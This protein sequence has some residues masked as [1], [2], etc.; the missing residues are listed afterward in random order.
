MFETRRPVPPGSAL[1]W[2]ALL[3][4]LFH[5]PLAIWLFAEPLRT[6]TAAL[7]AA[8]QRPMWPT[9]VVA[10]AV[11][12]LW[13]F[14]LALPFSLVPRAYRF[15]APL[16]TALGTVFLA[17]DA[18]VYGALGFHVNAFVL[19]VAMQPDALVQTGIPPREAAV[20]ALQALAFVAADV[21]VGAWFLRRFATARRT[22]RWALV[23]LLLGVTER[24]AVGA[25]T[26]YGGPGIF[27]AG[28]VL[29]QQVP[30][31]IGNLMRKVTGRE[32][33]VL[34]DPFSGETARLAAQLP[35]G[36][37]PADVK[38]TR[39]PDVLLVVTEST[40][41]TFLNPEVM[42]RMWKR[43]GAGAR[44]ER[45]YA[46]ANATSY[47]IFGLLFGMQAYRQEAVLGAGRRPLLF[48]ALRDH[49]YQLQFIAASSLDWMGLQDSVFADVKDALQ[50][51]L[52]GGGH[53]RDLE[54]LKR[55]RAYVEQADPSTPIFLFLFF[56]GTH[57]N[58]TYPERSAVFAPA[59]DGQGSV[60]VTAADHASV[61]NRARNAAHEVDWLTD[62]FLEW[63]QARRGGRQP[64]VVYT[65][66]HG[67]EF[68]EKGHMAH[69]NALTS[70]QIQVPMVILGEGVTP[71]VRREVTSH[72]DVVPTL[73]RLLGDGHDP[74][75][76]SDGFDMF[77]IPP[78]RFAMSTIGWEPEYAAVGEDLKVVFHALGVTVTDPEDR[79][80]PDGGARMA[81]ASGAIFRALGKD[82]GAASKAGAP[83]P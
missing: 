21:A 36:L 8:F 63:F 68:G 29:P 47:T 35:E 12:S 26:F 49:G 2:P 66:D 72:V 30:L 54:M 61:K 42:P 45:H 39:R 17:I 11:L 65:G 56:E 25:L 77:A 38:L 28:Q 79:P 9:Y 78:G 34:R 40:P 59:W 80:L 23:L 32:S 55:A 75:A 70:E 60:K 69:A 16:A 43:S 37:A 4:A 53:T 58:Y 31:R 46:A 41:S 1:R 10:A 73:L 48:G 13:T 24:F 67:E 71:G 14:L 81:K 18:R 74:R 64:V 19:Q 33:K 5:A 82:R 15:A 3:W 44:F 62:E 22:W 6:A 50:T 83:A 76:Y 27:A 57:F 52:P 20:F 7:P 51:N